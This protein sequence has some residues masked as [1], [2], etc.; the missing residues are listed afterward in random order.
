MTRILVIGA[1]Q[2]GLAILKGL[3][4]HPSKPTLTVLLRP[5]LFPRDKSF[6]GRLTP[7][8]SL[9]TSPTSLKQ[10]Y[11]PNSVA[12]TS[13][14]PLRAL[15]A[16]VPWFIPWQFGV[17]YDKIGRG[18]SQPLF[19][20][21]LD[22]RDMLRGQS[23]T[24]WTII[25]TGIF[26]SFLFDPAFGVIHRKGHGQV[27]VNALGKWENRV[28]MTSAEDIGRLTAAIVC[29]DTS[30]QS[31]VIY[32]AGETAS[33]D[34][35]ADKL[36]AS[37]WEVERKLT[38]VDELVQARREHPEDLG[39]KY[40]LIWARNVGVSWDFADT[41]NARNGIPVQGLD[42]WIDRNFRP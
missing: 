26:T 4:S 25:S 42:D 18:S 13:S 33:F 28:T 11:P 30:G 32:V 38:T 27:V 16:H 17:D 40:Q 1:G 19:D 29:D 34:G 14:S 35:L 41:W 9:C 22:V 10:I 31:E 2:L 7:F 37:G 3:S 39:P 6:W 21:Q 24:R 12:T 5:Q 23:T 8:K 15:Q 20:E 36:Q